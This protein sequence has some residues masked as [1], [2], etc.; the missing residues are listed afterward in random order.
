MSKCHEPCHMQ[1]VEVQVCV[2]WTSTGV[3][4]FVI[5]EDVELQLLSHECVSR[6]KDK[7]YN[8]VPGYLSEL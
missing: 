7:V 3:N 4:S 1:N 6:S 5:K 2:K 8:H